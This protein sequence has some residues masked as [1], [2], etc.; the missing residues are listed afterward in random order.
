MSD[1]QECKYGQLY[2][3]ATPIGNLEDIT[4]RAI[5]IL[6]EVDL[7]AAEDTRHTRKLLS[8]LGLSKPLISYYKDREIARSEK[9]IEELMNGHNVALVSDAGTPCISDPGA[10]LVRLCREA[11][12]HVVPVPGPSAVTTFLS[13]SGL[14]HSSFTFIGFI[15]S[16]KSQCRHTLTAHA[17]DDSI[18]VFYDSPRRIRK[19]LAE[20]KHVLGDRHVCLGRELTKIYEEIFSGSLTEII[21]L[22]DNRDQIKGEFV[23]AISPSD[24]LPATSPGTQNEEDLDDMLR[25]YRDESGLSLKDSVK[26][27]AKDLNLSRSNVYKTAL[28]IWQEK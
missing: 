20:C 11:G 26:K 28:L 27:I 21:S 7:V 4:L 14:P 22:L 18:L 15:P 10:V 16:K 3:L 8:H 12:I 2:V 25:W 6:G 24:E 1:P 5:R 13:V 9:I 23:V 19:T 17:Q